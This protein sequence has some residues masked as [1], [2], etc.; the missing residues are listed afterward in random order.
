MVAEEDIKDDDMHKSLK[1]DGAG[2]RKM[3]E[4]TLVSLDFHGLE[5][6]QR[7]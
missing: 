4:L 2:M 7:N 1:N 5:S 3:S 6:L